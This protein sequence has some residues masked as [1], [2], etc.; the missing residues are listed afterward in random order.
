MND[1]FL[2]MFAAVCLYV[3]SRKRKKLCS[4]SSA[5]E[6]KY[7]TAIYPQCLGVIIPDTSP[8]LL[9]AEVQ[10]TLVQG[11][12]VMEYCL[13]SAS[14]IIEVHKR[15]LKEEEI[16]AICEGVLHGLHYLHALG[17]IHRD[18]KAGNILLTENG[19]VKLG[20]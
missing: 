11:Q 12:L 17:R 1:E 14:D 10:N 3:K 4:T 5:H 6:L 7:V 15:P 8:I 9:S 2:L 18:V 13:G 16:A 19:T 20:E